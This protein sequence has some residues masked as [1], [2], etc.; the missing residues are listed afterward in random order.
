MYSDAESVQWKENEHM[1]V[2]ILHCLLVL[3][4][5][6]GWVDGSNDVRADGNE[7]K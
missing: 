7:G 3:R 2:R 4:L 5:L 6:G 1:S